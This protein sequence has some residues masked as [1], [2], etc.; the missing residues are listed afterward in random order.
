MTRFPKR[1]LLVLAL[2][3]TLAAPAWA[4][5]PV[6]PRAAFG[7]PD[8]PAPPAD[9]PAPA[10][11]GAFTVSDIRVDG[12]QRIGA[13]TVFTYLPIERGDRIDQSTVGDAI[14]ALYR[15]GFFQ[16][17][18]MGRQGDIL[19]I[20][21]VERPAINRLTLT[22]NKDIQ[23]EDL[24]RGL[25]DIGL[26]EGDTFDRLALDRV[27]QELTRQ[28]NNRGKYNVQ[29]TPTVS[30]LDRNRVDVTIVIDEGEAAKIRHINIVGNE[31]Y[32][33][34]LLREAWESNTSNWLSWYRRDDQYSREKL[35]G[36][37]EKLHNFYLDR[38]H[39]DFSEDSIQVAISPDRQ[40]MYITAGISE[41]EVYTVSGVEVSGDTVLPKED[42]QARLFVRE[43]QVFSRALLELSSDAI[44]ATL[45]NIGYAFA[46]V[47][48]IPEVNRDDR[49]V[50]I[51]M[52]VVPGPRVNVRRVVFRGNTRTADQVLRREM[53][54]FEGAWYSQAAIDRSRIRLQRLG[55]FE[56]GSVS[57]ETEPV[58]GTPDQV[59]V[60]VN[61]TET[62]SG[63]FTF[64]LGYSQLA[65]VTTSIQ[66]SQNNFLGSGN[67]VS[68][69]ASRNLFLQRYA[70][71]YTN[72][73]F[74]DD[75]L[76]MGYNLWWREF[77]NSEFN[78]AQYSSTSAAGQMFFG[79]PI[80]EHDSFSVLFG[81]DRN[82]IFAW[83]GATPDSIVDYIDA[84]GSRTFHAWRTEVGWARD[85]RNDF[86]QPTRGTYQ[87]VSAE[88]TLPG[89]TAE[90]YKLNYEFSKYWPLHRTMVL[91]T[92]TEI[93]YGD[94]YGS[95]VTRN[96]CF[97]PPPPP[98]QDNPFPPA[99][100][101]SGWR[102]S[103]GSSV[104]SKHRRRCSSSTPAKVSSVSSAL[105]SGTAVRSAS[106]Q[107][108]ARYRRSH[109]ARSRSG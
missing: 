103:P 30:N 89:S 16:D 20:S 79:V 39:L 84:F 40:D 59:D 68:I 28:Y 31:V 27:T 5:Q 21:V 78:T 99:P 100:P 73:Y 66:L 102:S 7:F 109:A 82:E 43:G 92:R 105:R 37:R 25:A 70:F 49:T 85:T 34:D 90:Y 18:R 58:P 95:D 51:N 10:A 48:P 57:V 4:Q 93:G 52:Q 46:Q 77:D 56:S 50:T 47:N 15:T 80:T 71:S 108:Q 86:L 98:T 87:R 33:D 63:N 62:A 14:R 42:I 104:R 91:N 3:T 107:L 60:V 41:G 19:V 38:G 67:R 29:I 64:G 13:G 45:S 44:I 1:R 72:P 74:T 6:D 65:G 22:G 9:A 96:V 24:M 61:V 11:T 26:S 88:I 94:S 54:Q 75:G 17:V 76:S 106:S 32:D 69:E 2:A 53:R 83:R 8:A 97:T 55:F 36:D 35:D 101:P 23:T 81:I 12:L